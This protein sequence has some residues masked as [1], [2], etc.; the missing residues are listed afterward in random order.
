[1]EVGCDSRQ[2]DRA[3]PFRQGK[4]FV[5][6]VDDIESMEVQVS[7]GFPHR[8]VTVG[9]E[10]LLN[11]NP[12]RWRPRRTKRSRRPSSAPECVPQK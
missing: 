11:S 1:M 6:G 8:P 7:D 10:V 4:R 5:A 9:A 2:C 12:S 3:N